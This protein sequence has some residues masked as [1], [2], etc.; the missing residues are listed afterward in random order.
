M[1]MDK[2]QEN[3]LIQ[4]AQKNPEAFGELFDFYY[5]AILRYCLSR[6]GNAE[7]ARDITSE[8]FFKAVKNLQ[9]Y[10]IT[11]VPFSAWLYRIASNE[12]TDS[13]RRK[14]YEPSSYDEYLEKN[15]IEPPSMR[16]DLQQEVNDAQEKL[17]NTRDF[18]A[19]V[20]AIKKLPPV[21]QEAL[22]LRFVEDK[23][24][25]EIAQIT[26]KKEGTV[27]SL[28]SRGIDMLKKMMQ[29]KISSPVK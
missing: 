12:I 6:T 28:L 29:P 23:S 11:S 7:T 8:V 2:T 15:G 21:Y 16:A 5:P 13:F 22:V 17:M 10:K 9:K 25:L 3:I 1:N 4:N 19:A 24:I 27:K 14:K 26:G 18:G 20:E